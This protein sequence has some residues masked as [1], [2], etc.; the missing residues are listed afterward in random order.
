MVVAGCGVCPCV[1]WGGVEV[2]GCVDA[3]GDGVDGVWVVGID[4]CVVGVAAN[5]ANGS[6]SVRD[7]L[8][9]RFTWLTSVAS[10]STVSSSDLLI[11]AV[12]GFCGFPSCW[13]VCLE[14]G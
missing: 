1:G 13:D 9:S 6:G 2:E 10:L 12:W 8:D 14:M 3:A 4:V 5:G 7:G 11:A